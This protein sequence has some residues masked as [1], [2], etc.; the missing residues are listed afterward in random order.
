MCDVLFGGARSGDEL[1]IE[2]DTSEAQDDDVGSD[3]GRNT[4]RRAALMEWRWR[5]LAGGMALPG[6][7]MRWAAAEWNPHASVHSHF[8]SDSSLEVETQEQQGK[9]RHPGRVV[10]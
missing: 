1:Q 7:G 2:I 6:G 8:L 3:K 9:A 4:D 5:W 10:P